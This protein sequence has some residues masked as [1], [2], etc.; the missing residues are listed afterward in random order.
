MQD[1]IKKLEQEIEYEQMQYDIACEYPT[2]TEQFYKGLEKTR[3]RIVGL[4][5]KLSELKKQ[6]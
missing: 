1:E 4:K 5:N 6:V 2:Q 3:Q